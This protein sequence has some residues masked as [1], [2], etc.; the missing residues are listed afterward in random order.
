MDWL[1]TLLGGVGISPPRRPALDGVNVMPALL[2]ERPPIP[3]KLFWRYSAQHQEA[4]RDGV[5]KYF[6]VND[7]EF[8]FDVV[9]DPLER[10]NLKHRHPEVFEQLKRSTRSGTPRCCLILR[11]T[12]ATR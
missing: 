8:L 11:G 10:A 1:P 4:M 5:W 2:G 9:A 12:V 6:K 3:R 7:Y